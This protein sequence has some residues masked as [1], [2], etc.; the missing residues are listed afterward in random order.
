M[1]P[2]LK[3]GPECSCGTVL[4]PIS[5]DPMV[6]ACRKCDRPVQPRAETGGVLLRVV[7]RCLFIAGMVVFLVAIG[8]SIR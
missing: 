8:D 5:L 1:I 6:L 4:Y 3:Q 2:V 7:Y